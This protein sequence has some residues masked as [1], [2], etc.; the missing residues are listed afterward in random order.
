M[1]K[2]SD[3]K[4]IWILTYLLTGAYDL[5]SVSSEIIEQ[6]KR[7]KKKTDPNYYRDDKNL[8]PKEVNQRLDEA[9]GPKT[10]FSIHNFENNY[11]K[12]N[13]EEQGMHSH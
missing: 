2:K 8:T 13:A 4:R 3:K 9:F 11:D 6:N 12:L 7:L 10:D 1:T 5:N